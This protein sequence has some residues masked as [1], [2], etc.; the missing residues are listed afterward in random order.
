MFLPSNTYHS[1]INRE[2]E[3]EKQEKRKKDVKEERK[4]K[5]EG[6]EENLLQFHQ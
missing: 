5:N 1:S 4:K 3:A 2:R 6:R